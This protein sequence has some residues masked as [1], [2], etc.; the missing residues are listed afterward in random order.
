MRGIVSLSPYQVNWLT[1]RVAKETQSVLPMRRRIF[2]SILDRLT[3]FT[4]E[5]MLQPEVEVKIN[6]QG[7]KTIYL[8]LTQFIELCKIQLDEYNRRIGENQSKA[9]VYKPYI[10]KCN[11]YIQTA[12]IIRA[13]F[14]RGI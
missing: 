10:D 6:R 8:Y 7:R 9:K 5:E 12:T 4:D 11:D 14:E 1:L 13:R 3:S 2:S